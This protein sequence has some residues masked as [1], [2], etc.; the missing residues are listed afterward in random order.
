[1]WGNSILRRPTYAHSGCQDVQESEVTARRCVHVPSL[2]SGKVGFEDKTIQQCEVKAMD[3]DCVP[4]QTLAVARST[5]ESTN[6]YRDAPKFDL[7]RHTRDGWLMST[8]GQLRRKSGLS[9]Q[10]GCF[11]INTDATKAIGRISTAYLNSRRSD[12]M[13]IFSVFRSFC[14][15]QFWP[16]YICF[17]MPSQTQP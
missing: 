17:V 1:M 9:K 7:E 8:S 3:S 6:E 5:V 10:D 15:R 14:L 11:T 16:L 12:V 4:A 13:H 2:F